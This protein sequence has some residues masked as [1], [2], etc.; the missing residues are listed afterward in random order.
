MYPFVWNKREPIICYL[1]A[2]WHSYVVFPSTTTMAERI[3]TKQELT[4]FESFLADRT[5]SRRAIALCIRAALGPS[6]PR[7]RLSSTHIAPKA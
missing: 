2:N 5:L 1:P 7:S 6:R 3:L 4:L